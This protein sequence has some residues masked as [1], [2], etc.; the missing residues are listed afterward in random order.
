MPARL[1]AALAC[2]A[3]AALP[4]GAAGKFPQPLSYARPVGNG[5]VFVQLGDPAEEAKHATASQKEEFA[6]LRAKYPASGLYAAGD[7]PTLKW[8]TPPSSYTPYDLAFVTSDGRHL[9][10]VEGDFWQTESFPGGIRPSAEVQA[11]LLA[12]PALSFL[13]DGK[14]VKQYT[15][16]ELVPDPEV[17]KH[18]P[19]HLIW[20]ASAVLLDGGRFTLFTQDQERCTFDA[21]TGELLSRERVGLANPVLRGILVACGVFTALILAGWLLFVWKRRVPDSVRLAAK[22]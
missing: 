15:L 13:T 11:K 19:K 3:L 12:A 10:A 4:A 22:P 21:A 8:A 1:L 14:L 20:Y 7:P 2:L 6:Q 9:V 16:A 5:L 18:T 17:L